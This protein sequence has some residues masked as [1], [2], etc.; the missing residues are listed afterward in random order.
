LFRSKLLWRLYAG[1][2]V[3]ILVTGGLIGWLQWRWQAVD[4]LQTVETELVRVVSTTELDELARSGL[5]APSPSPAFQQEVQSLAEVAGVRLTVI[6]EDGDVFADSERDPNAMDNHG[7]RPEV[8]EARR[9]AGI[10]RDQRQSGTLDEGYVYVARVLLTPAGDY[11]GT[12]RASAPE[13]KVFAR[14]GVIVRNVALGTLVAIG[15]ASL[16]GL[17]LAR[18]FTV[19]VQAMTQVVDSMVHGNY[20]VRV[21]SEGGDELAQLAESFNTLASELATRV[22]TITTDRNRLRAIL[23]SMVEGVIAVDAD[24]NIVHINE[25]AAGLLELDPE[26]V[27]GKPLRDTLRMDALTTALSF[28]LQSAVFEVREV[29]LP[30]EP[31]D[32]VVTVHGAPLRDLEGRPEGAVLVLHEVTRLRRLEGMRRDF[33]A[34]VSHELKTPLTA[35]QGLC[36]TLIED[37]QMP[38]ELRQRFLGKIRAQCN[39]QTALVTDLLAL[40]KLDADETDPDDFVPCDLRIAVEESIRGQRHVAEGKGLTLTAKVPAEAIFAVGEPGA[41]QQIVDNL[42]SNAIKYTP[43]GGS[44]SVLLDRVQGR[45]VLQVADTGIGISRKHQERVFERF[46]RVDKARSRNL[47]GTGLGLAIVKNI[48]LRLGGTV[49]LSS[50][51]GEGSTFRVSF[52]VTATGAAG[53]HRA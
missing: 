25:V 45:A 41:F 39:R 16:V 28:S 1:F 18:R 19:P 38:R 46:Y 33:V 14:Y 42:L 23:G 37:P 6:A 5:A 8:V 9:N 13:A 27:V 32:R 11:L 2:V 31:R 36:E 43:E 21:D 53:A 3:V 40:S 17:V 29:V 22:A 34:N 24:E 4:A 35:I 30:D 47:G 7:L 49:D 51:P 44:V 52:P 50:A 26:A 15:I 20:Y 12:L 10:G 48:V